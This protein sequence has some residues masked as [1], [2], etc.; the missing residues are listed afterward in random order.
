VALFYGGSDYLAD[1]Q[2]VQR[3]LS[4]LP[5]AAVVH[6]QYQPEYAHLDYTWA[7]NAHEKVYGDVQDLLRKYAS[8]D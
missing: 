5:A 7:E 6:T 8:A 1:P 4:E 3:L 2:D